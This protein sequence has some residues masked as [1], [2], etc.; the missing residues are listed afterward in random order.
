MF[1]I[2]QL[3]LKKVFRLVVEKKPDANGAMQLVPS[4]FN[5]VSLYVFFCVG[6]IV[7]LFLFFICL[8]VCF[9]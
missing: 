4:V 5:F 7:C 3:S 6:L 8:F 9:I 1:S 2:I